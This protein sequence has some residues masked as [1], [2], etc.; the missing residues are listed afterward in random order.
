M[1][2]I[3][4]IMKVALLLLTIKIGLFIIKFIFGNLIGSLALVADSINSGADIVVALGII[5]GIKFSEREA[6]PKYPYGLHKI[7]NMVELFIAVGIFYAGYVILSES[8]L[9]FGTTTT[10]NPDLGL[11]ITGISLI[12]TVIL[13]IY[14][15]RKGRQMNSPMIIAEGKDSKVDIL[16]TSLVFIG[17]MGYYF[18]TAIL[19][20]IVGIIL[21]VLIFKVGLDILIHSSKV[22]LDAVIN[23]DK[24]DSIRQIIEGTPRVISVDNLHARSAGRYYFINADIKTSLKLMKRVFDLKNNLQDEIKSKFPELY[25][26]NIHVEPEK[27]EILRYAIPLSENNGLDSTI[28]THFGSAPLF[29]FY[30]YK[31]GGIVSQTYQENP[32]LSEEKR[33][34]ILVGEWLAKNS[35]DKVLV[36]EDLKGGAK[37]ALEKHLIDTDIVPFTILRD[38]EMHLNKHLSKKL[39]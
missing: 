8:I 18:G 21:A 19:E 32:F 1:G 26:V 25:K 30:D 10:T 39:D 37:L 31:A 4:T 38:L 15:T 35:V 23:Y 3:S 24:L 11:L 14:L 12:I 7:E 33:K 9:K 13:M 36:K 6:S 2:K 29:A 28:A 17:L 16:S 34:G 27:K 20:P 5:I 22:L